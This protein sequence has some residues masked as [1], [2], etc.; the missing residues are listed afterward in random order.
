M[1]ISCPDCLVAI[2]AEQIN[3]KNDLAF[4][5]LCNKAFKISENI[6]LT[7]AKEPSPKKAL[8]CP[9]GAWRIEEFDGPIIGASTRSFIAFFL[10]PFMLVWSGF[11]IG[12]IY[13][14]QIAQ[15][16]FNI[17]LSL[18]GLPFLAGSLLFGSMTLM[19][20]FG[21]VEIR[22]SFE[23]C[24]FVGIGP[25]GWKKTFTWQGITSI[26]EKKEYSRKGGPSYA[27]VISGSKRIKFGS[28]L[29]DERRYF[30][31]ESLKRLHA[32]KRQSPK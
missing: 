18:F 4:C 27:I 29:N 8:I 16:E 11:S 6:E 21:K 25:F 5:E 3:I 28:M 14:Y 19:T 17:L 12:G 9:N 32:Q 24:I 22:D 31:L 23:P 2:K 30:I 13:G 1:Q 7:S 15:G 10:V 26:E 20:I